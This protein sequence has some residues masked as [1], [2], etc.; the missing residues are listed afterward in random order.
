[1][2]RYAIS[3][4]IPLPKKNMTID[5]FEYSIGV[6]ETESARNREPMT[7]EIAFLST[8]LRVVR[9]KI[10]ENRNPQGTTYD[11]ISVQTVSE[12]SR[13]KASLVK[14]TERLR[15]YKVKM[16]EEKETADLTHAFGVVTEETQQLL[17]NYETKIAFLQMQILAGEAA[18]ARNGVSRGSDTVMTDDT[19]TNAEYG[20]LQMS[21]S[22]H[23]DHF[24]TQ[25]EVE[26]QDDLQRA[27]RASMV[28][29]GMSKENVAQ[30]LAE[31]ALQVLEVSA[32]DRAADKA[33]DDKMEVGLSRTDDWQ[34]GQVGTQG[35]TISKRVR[36]ESPNTVGPEQVTSQEAERE[37]KDIQS[38]VEPTEP[39]APPST[40][41]D[42]D[43]DEMSWIQGSPVSDNDSLFNGSNEGEILTD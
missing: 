43:G 40:S 28:D 29:Q 15:R 24:N 5:D 26:F 30:T 18:L 38:S 27:L 42:C 3:H 1:M 31:Q 4:G 37:G 21:A 11:T 13:E 6:A 36:F 16:L 35:H 19:G 25:T 2:E 9:S 10:E 17:D 12:A 41:H 39:Q 8:R 33:L 7:E 14:E 20:L 22:S 23:G 32:R 34:L